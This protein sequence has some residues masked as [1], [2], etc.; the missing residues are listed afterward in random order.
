M[1]TIGDKNYMEI[2]EFAKKEN[3]SI[4]TIYNWITSKKIKTR[5]LLNKTIIEV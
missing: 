4:Q 2:D 1:I 3:K 5:K